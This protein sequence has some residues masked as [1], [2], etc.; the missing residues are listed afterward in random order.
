ML[1]HINLVEAIPSC[2]RPILILSPYIQIMRVV[3]LLQISQPKLC[4]SLLPRAQP[5]SSSVIGQPSNVICAA[6]TRFFSL[7]NF[8][9][10]PVTWS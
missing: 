1:R 3:S 6:Q 7:A 2:L 8:L 4:V 9:L 10:L 5:I